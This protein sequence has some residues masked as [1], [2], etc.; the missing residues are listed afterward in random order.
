M[1]FKFQAI[2]YQLRR[3]PLFDEFIISYNFNNDDENSI[4][5]M[6]TA[7]K[8]Y[9]KDRAYEMAEEEEKALTFLQNRLIELCYEKNNKSLFFIDDLLSLDGNE[10]TEFNTDWEKA[11]TDRI[12]LLPRDRK[13]YRTIE[14]FFILQ[15]YNDD[16]IINKYSSSNHPL[17]NQIIGSA[18]IHGGFYRKGTPLLY[19]GVLNANNPLNPYWNSIYGVFG[20][21][22][23]LWEFVRIYGLKKFKDKYSEHYAN[24]IKL[25][26]LYLSRSIVLSELKGAPQ[27]HDFYRNR[28]DF[29]RDNYSI[30]MTI[31]MEYGFFITNMEVQFTS[32]CFRAFKICSDLG[33]PQLGEQ[34]MKD[35]YKMYKYGSLN[36]FCEDNGLK[37]IEDATFGE[38]VDRGYLRANVVAENILK[39]YKVGAIRIPDYIF[40]E[41]LVDILNSHPNS[42]PDYDWINL[43]K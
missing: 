3:L 32:D 41:M 10:I 5:S 35:A 24:L 11:K 21:T 4:N 27:G 1:D 31:F 23:S 29:Q 43:K 20:C 39:E 7:F 28:A 18:L 26:Y 38:L 16:A 40:E 15:E 17:I 14:E 34:A 22:L 6:F 2:I 33:A 8:E 42:S 19:K 9:R 36:I 25:I 12:A 30:M 13:T 37:A